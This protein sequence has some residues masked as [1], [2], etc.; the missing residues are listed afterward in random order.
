MERAGL[1]AKIKVLIVNYDCTMPVSPTVCCRHI[2]ST[3]ESSLTTRRCIGSRGRS[4][5][6]VGGRGRGHGRCPG[7]SSASL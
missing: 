7:R 2:L 1:S 5:Y 4:R 3:V 6:G